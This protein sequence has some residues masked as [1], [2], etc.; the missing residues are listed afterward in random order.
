VREA[1]GNRRDRQGDIDALAASVL[2]QHAMR[3]QSLPSLDVAPDPSSSH[4][5]DASSSP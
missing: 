5:S 2:L 4:D 1:G 3:I